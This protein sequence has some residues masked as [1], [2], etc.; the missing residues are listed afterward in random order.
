MSFGALPKLESRHSSSLNLL[1]SNTMAHHGERFGMSADLQAKA[2]AKYSV[3]LEG[4][5]TAWLE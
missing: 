4:E 3:E 5:A 2:G 1:P